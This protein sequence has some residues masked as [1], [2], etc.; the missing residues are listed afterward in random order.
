MQRL[1]S[2]VS[3]AA[4]QGL[5]TPN[6]VR[7]LPARMSSRRFR[8]LD[9]VLKRFG[10]A[11]F[12]APAEVRPL[13]K[14]RAQKV[15]G[16]AA[17]PSAEPMA[18]H[19]N[20]RQIAQPVMAHKLHAELCQ[21]YVAQ[22]TPRE[23]CSFMPSG[24]HAH[25]SCCGGPCLAAIIATAL[26]WESQQAHSLQSSLLSGLGIGISPVMSIP[27]LASCCPCCHT[28]LNNSVCPAGAPYHPRRPFWRARAGT[29]Q[30]QDHC[31]HRHGHRHHPHALHHARHPPQSGSPAA[32]PH[33]PGGPPLQ[34]TLPAPVLARY[35]CHLNAAAWS[36]TPTDSPSANL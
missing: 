12:S 34:L 15:S 10:N 23:A 13:S 26:S 32:Q 5:P 8:R 4:W 24:L 9:S 36:V 29:L 27:W 30:L 28:G 21:P 6:P 17:V 33:R 2:K 1:R 35:Q 3:Q 11:S 7:S 14:P 16:H 25:T 18:W 20:A 31:P 19:A 22:Q